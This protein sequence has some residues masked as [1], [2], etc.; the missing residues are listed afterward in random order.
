M[1]YNNNEIAVIG[2]ACRFPGCPDASSYWTNLI[3]GVNCIQLSPGK[4]QSPVLGLLEEVE[5]FDYKFFTMNPRDASTLDPRQRLFLQ[6][7]FH[8][9]E[10]AGY[11][12]DNAY[13]SNTGVFIGI[14]NNQY[15][16]NV[17]VSGEGKALD[18]AN[19]SVANR[20]SFFM[21]FSGPS[22]TVDSTCSASANA[23][24]LA[25][26]SLRN[27]ECDMAVSG[28]VHV[29]LDG[30]SIKGLQAMSI[31][32]ESG[33]NCSFSRNADGFVPSEGVG[34]VVL[35]RYQD[36]IRDKDPIYAVI[37]GT[38]TNYAGRT[39]NLLAPNP[40]AQSQLIKQSLACC[41]ER[42][43]LYLE[44]NG[45]STVNGDFLEILSVQ[46]A[47]R[48]SGFQKHG[49]I[50]FGSV[51]NNIGNCDPVSGIASLIKVILS[52]EHRCIPPTINMEPFNRFIKLDNSLLTPCTKK[53]PIVSD[54]HPQHLIVSSFG[55]GGTN[56][57]ITV[58]TDDQ[59]VQ[60]PENFPTSESRGII[61]LS[62]HTGDSLREIAATVVK[63][64]G[65]AES[66]IPWATAFSAS[67]NSFSHRLFCIFDSREDLQRQLTSFDFNAKDLPVSF[68]NI[69]STE[70]EKTQSG[71][72]QLLRQ[73][74]QFQETDSIDL[75]E[76]IFTEMQMIKNIRPCLIV[77]QNAYKLLQSWIHTVHDD[78]IFAL[79]EMFAD[80]G[81]CFSGLIGISNEKEI[82]AF[83]AGY[84]SISTKNTNSGDIPIPI[85]EPILFASFE[86]LEIG[87][88]G[89][90]IVIGELPEV[91]YSGKIYRLHESGELQLSFL[92]LLGEL[93]QDGL[94]VNWKRL[95]YPTQKEIL[96]RLPFY[97]FEKH[98]CWVGHSRMSC[99][100][101]TGKKEQNFS[102][103]AE[104]TKEHVPKPVQS[105]SLLMLLCEKIAEEYGFSVDE[106]D[107][108]V[109]ISN[110]GLDSLFVIVQLPVIV[111]QL[112]ITIEP[113]QLTHC[114]TLRQFAMEID[115]ESKAMV[116]VTK[117]S[118]ETAR[119]D[120]YSDS[121]ST[122]GV[123]VIGMAG[124]FPEA[125]NVEL[126]WQNLIALRSA[127]REIPRER[128]D[129]DM[130]YS[131]QP[132]A[133]GKSISKWI[134]AIEDIE[135]F[136]HQHFSIHPREA[137]C[138][139]PQH[140]LI[141]QQVRQCLADAGIHRE[142]LF[143]RPVGVFIGASN[144]E[145][146]MKLREK[147]FE[148]ISAHDALGVSHA[149]IANRVS[150]YL[151][152]TG[153]SMVI[154]TAC[155]SSLSALYAAYKSLEDGE[156]D[157]AIVGGVNVVMHVSSFISLSK[158]KMLSSDGVCRIFDQNGDGTVRGDGVG[159]ILLTSLRNATK[160]GRR[161]QAVIR[162]AGVS[163][164]GESMGIMLPTAKGIRHCMESVWNRQG[165]DPRKIAC[166]ELGSFGSPVSDPI[167][168][169]AINS[170]LSFQNEQ[171]C[172]YLGSL[173][174]LVGHL[175]AASGIAALIKAI[176]I[177]QRG[178]I[179]PMVLP[180]E[181]NS[182]IKLDNSRF[183][184]N[185]NPIVM[186]EYKQNLIAVNSFGF[187]GTIGHA[188]I[189]IPPGAS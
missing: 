95:V 12:G 91:T 150:N 141:L 83:R 171:S 81:I 70:K 14:S 170:A 8:A 116:E 26:Q 43:P 123:I 180:R 120:S 98:P 93:W 130:F 143:G 92:I 89:S 166:L 113:S 182:S 126:F 56:V 121:V 39:R 45:A 153:P 101:Q 57:C 186:D 104:L 138:M 185:G 109:H 125:E 15:V 154:D 136:D 77:T 54:E 79:G 162:G 48:D 175:E 31:V 177:A 86:A 144:V 84:R 159:V 76:H 151:K 118:G 64:I 169:M 19:A 128:W 50:A 131:P 122:T 71:I 33:C 13:G 94:S 80:A 51:K 59:P 145:M 67:R 187:G 168:F 37:S 110:Y 66:L 36:A 35:K 40:I 78:P 152:S 16:K 1:T 7:G 34:A 134:A 60:A 87:N 149:L 68:S 188:I 181:L 164:K 58:R 172:C 49:N 127:I 115:P 129:V 18:N 160:S 106:L 107:P 148:A 105:S 163:Y 189:G 178:I 158:A 17:A 3:D 22:F 46:H 10:C 23:V 5:Q 142:E 75:Q 41:S 85:P 167:E 24:H 63:S 156:C 155:S 140:R 38:F 73:Y 96:S 112:N 90:L 157:Y 42:L 133:R 146:A 135:S 2:Y 65:D 9:L 53:L 28:G 179:P 119:L 161:I 44:L 132:N 108:D 6:T 176:C 137:G 47:L 27:N 61:A 29:L 32:S 69:L 97:P 20:F 117:S 102:H 165:I 114:S 184:M 124:L 25:C 147:S 21:N 55:V 62:A 111:A 103:S 72:H 99:I 52:I 82:K 74:K 11:G 173:K 100:S 4:E 139:D 183:K 30:Q 174:P 88:Q